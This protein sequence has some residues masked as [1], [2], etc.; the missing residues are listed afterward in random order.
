VPG[1]GGQTEPSLE[2]PTPAPVAPDIGRPRDPVP[3]VGAPVHADAEPRGW[4]AAVRALLARLVPGRGARAGATQAAELDAAARTADQ[5]A[6]VATPAAV[7][8]PATGPFSLPATRAATPTPAPAWE[9]TTPDWASAAAPEPAAAPRTS[10]WATPPRLPAE[11]SAAQG[12]KPP[13]ESPAPPP[14][15]QPGDTAPDFLSRTPTNVT[16]VADDFFD[17]L[18]R[19]IEGDR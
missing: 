11:Q 4:L 19:R 5:S 6:P 8:A 3:L 9:L 16:L 18:I 14:R 10:A 13:E 2:E 7:P 17:G 12:R 15:R 1:S